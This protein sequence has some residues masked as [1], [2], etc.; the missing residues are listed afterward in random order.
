[1]IFKTCENITPSFLVNTSTDIIKEEAIETKKEGYK[2]QKI[3]NNVEVMAT[4]IAEM[5]QTRE[6]IWEK[7]MLL[8]KERLEVEKERWAYERQKEEREREKMKMDFDLK[9]KALELKYQKKD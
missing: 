4:A 2:K 5:S 1:M 7:K 8:E 6:R 9:M 3:K